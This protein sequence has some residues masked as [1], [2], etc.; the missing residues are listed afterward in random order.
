MN[1]QN[2]PVANFYKKCQSGVY[3]FG[4]DLEINKCGQRKNVS[5]DLAESYNNI[6]NRIKELEN[7]LPKYNDDAEMEKQILNQIINLA[8][9]L[10]GISENINQ[11]NPE[12]WNTID[13]VN[14]EEG[15]EEL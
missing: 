8:T 15:E 13:R 1:S 4:G 6:Y 2:D 12:L 10:E 7:D 9:D 5:I 3:G 14:N 11:T